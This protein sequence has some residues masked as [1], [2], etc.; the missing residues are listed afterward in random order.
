M[1]IMM[2]GIQELVLE[3]EIPKDEVGQPRK[4]HPPRGSEEAINNADYEDKYC[5]RD[6]K[7]VTEYRRLKQFCKVYRNG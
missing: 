1:L 4:Q 3:D 6:V 5:L 7:A 2:H